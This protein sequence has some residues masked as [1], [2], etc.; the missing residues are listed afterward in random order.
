[1]D[2]DCCLR[3]EAIASLLFFDRDQPSAIMPLSS[4]CH[5]DADAAQRRRK[6]PQ[7]TG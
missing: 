7:P 6:P 5:D 3:L 4:E 1:M 2:A